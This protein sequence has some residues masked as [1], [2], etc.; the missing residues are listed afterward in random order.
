MYDNI[1]DVFLKIYFMGIVV[2]V[3]L[4]ISNKQTDT[5]GKNNHLFRKQWLKGH[6]VVSV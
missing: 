2:C 4:L 1:N 6:Y 3:I 5:R